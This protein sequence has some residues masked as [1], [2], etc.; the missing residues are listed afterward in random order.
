M[1]QFRGGLVVKAHKLVYHSTLGW[2]V[3]NEEKTDVAD[4]A[5]VDASGA[6]PVEPKPAQHRMSHSVKVSGLVGGLNKF[7]PN[8]RRHAAGSLR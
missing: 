7:I 4:G 6:V 8:S 5:V 1:K 3:M 2:R